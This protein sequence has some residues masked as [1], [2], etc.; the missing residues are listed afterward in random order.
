MA[1]ATSFMWIGYDV[2]LLTSD[3]VSIRFTVDYYMAGAAHPNHYFRVLNYDLAANKEILFSDLFKDPEKALKVLSLASKKCLSKPDFP[4]FEEGILPKMENF[5][6][7]NLTEENLR[8][9]FDPY[10]VA[11]YA[12][13]PQEVLLPY[14]DIQDLVKSNSVAGKM[15]L[16]Q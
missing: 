10:Q 8:L 4:L 7:W 11:P 13:G 16:G 15:I 9:S 12:A 6:N 2:P 5:T 3:L 1:A 14:T